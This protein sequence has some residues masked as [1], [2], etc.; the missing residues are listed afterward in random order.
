[1]NSATNRETPVPGGLRIMEAVRLRVK[2]VDSDEQIAVRSVK[3]DEDRVTTFPASIIPRL[4]NHLAKVKVLH[5]G[6]LAKGH[7]EV[8]LPHALSRKYPGAGKEW[9]WQYLFP[10]VTCR[11]I[12]GSVRCGV[13]M[14]IPL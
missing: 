5:A 9:R 7:G 2:D 6:D 3:G 1:M 13:I 12:R 8:Y 4:E 14:W 11:L 10:P